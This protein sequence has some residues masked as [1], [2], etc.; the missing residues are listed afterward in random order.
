MGKKVHIKNVDIAEYYKD[1]FKFEGP[2]SMVTDFEFTLPDS[3]KKHIYLQPT[4]C[5]M[6]VKW[7]EI[8]TTCEIQA[9]DKP[10]PSN[11]KNKASIQAGNNSKSSKK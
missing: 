8:T 11:T 3:T 2:K 9:S 10:F 5:K 1:P 4:Q 7:K 6:E